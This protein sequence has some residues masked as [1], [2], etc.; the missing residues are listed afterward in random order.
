[1]GYVIGGH[2]WFSWVAWLWSLSGGMRIITCMWCYACVWMNVIRWVRCLN[3]LFGKLMGFEGNSFS[4][5]DEM[6]CVL[7]AICNSSPMHVESVLPFLKTLG[8]IKCCVRFSIPRDPM[9]TLSPV[10]SS[11]NGS[12]SPAWS[13]GR[14]FVRVLY[15][16]TCV[17][18]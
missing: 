15:S 16:L 11:G 6:V 13:S 18:Q 14:G 12:S 2:S 7:L 17:K 4:M 5:H 9:K 3:V 1:M 8:G 10:W